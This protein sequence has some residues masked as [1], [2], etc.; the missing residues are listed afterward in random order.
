MTAYYIKYQIR[1]KEQEYEKHIDA[2]D[3]RMAKRKI[4]KQHGYKDGRMVNILDTKVI[5][6][7]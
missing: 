2:V 1:G 4:G 3:L 5:G 7:L 6:Y